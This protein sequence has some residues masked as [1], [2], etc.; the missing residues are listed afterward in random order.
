MVESTHNRKSSKYSHN[1]FN[2]AWS[3]H[4]FGRGLVNSLL[5]HY[6]KLCDLQT[7]AVITCILGQHV[8][9][10]SPTSSRLPHSASNPFQSIPTE[11]PTFE[12]ATTSPSNVSQGGLILKEIPSSNP[13]SVLRKTANELKS[14]QL[15]I[16]RNSSYGSDVGNV[17]SSGGDEH[18]FPPRKISPSTLSTTTTYS[19]HETLNNSDSSA[20]LTYADGIE[21]ASKDSSKD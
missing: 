12:R 16:P 6:S 9:K 15:K 13:E 17:S 8:H 18:N 19:A 21:A 20:T 11:T 3:H 2:T 7:A 4:P 5:D 1:P 14:M 10:S